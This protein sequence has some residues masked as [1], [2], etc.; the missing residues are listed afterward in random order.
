MKDTIQLISTSPDELIKNIKIG[1]VE[2]VIKEL[3]TTLEKQPEE[4]LTPKEVCKLLKVDV[5][6]L[7]RWRNA[8]IITAYGL[9]NR[10]YFKRSE[11]I[12]QISKNKLN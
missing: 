12:K 3:K 5:S 2:E 8:N 10:V 11:L 7:H 6:T 9:G 1:L 4:F